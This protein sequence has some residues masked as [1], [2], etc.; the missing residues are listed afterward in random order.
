[1]LSKTSRRHVIITLV[2]LAVILA[3]CVSSFA[4]VLLPEAPGTKVKRDGTLTVD[5][6]HMDQGYVMV[7][8]PVSKKRLKVRIKTESVT[9][10]YDLNTAGEFEVYPLQFGSGKY[11]VA[12]YKNA[13]GNKYSEEGKVAI[14]VDMDNELSCFLYP[15]QY[16]NYNAD[17]LAVK[18]AEEICNGKTTEKDKFEAVCGY[19]KTNFVYDFIKSVT[20]AQGTMPDI[21]G[22]IQK[23][24]GICQDLAAVM[25]CM[26]RSQGIPARLMIGTVGAS[27]YHAWVTAVVDGKDVFYDPTA[28]LNAS[29]RDQQYTTER[30]Y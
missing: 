29:P 27:N 2:S 22:T 3:L 13:S 8:G 16:V 25:V 10:N 14:N 4:D 30:Y 24:M 20:V 21:D 9:L 12:L 23:R 28:E 17:S 5:C 19:M 7:K 6:S 1:M 18:Q 15:N 26:L 11:Q